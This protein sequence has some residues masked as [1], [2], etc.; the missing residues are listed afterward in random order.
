MSESEDVPLGTLIFLMRELL[1][2][3][4][5]RRDY[6]FGPGSFTDP[7]G[8]VLSAISAACC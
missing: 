8:N 3:A 5:Y 4:G 2:R 7:A 1:S 6:V